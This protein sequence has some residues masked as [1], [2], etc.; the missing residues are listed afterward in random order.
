MYY[1]CVVEVEMECLPDFFDRASVEEHIAATCTFS[2]GA[3]AI[4]CLATCVE[5]HEANTG[6]RWPSVR[7]FVYVVTSHHTHQRWLNFAD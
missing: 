5:A 1:M 2:L 3:L 6:K 4:D 7:L